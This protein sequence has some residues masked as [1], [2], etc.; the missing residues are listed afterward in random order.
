MGKEKDMFPIKK[1]I[2]VFEKTIP[3][4][5][6]AVNNVY[7]HSFIIAENINIGICSYPYLKLKIDIYDT[8]NRYYRN[9]IFNG[10]LFPTYRQ[11][12][13]IEQ[14]ILPRLEFMKSEVIELKKLLKKGYTHI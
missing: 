10:L 7:S 1:L 12:R 6:D 4:Y 8:I 2:D 5:Q 11:S 14:S 9:Y 13:S 3:I